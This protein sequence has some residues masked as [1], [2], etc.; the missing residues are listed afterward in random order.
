MTKFYDTNALLNLQGNVLDEY[1]NIS[2]VSLQEL[3]EIKTSRHKDEDVKTR[4]R[5]ILKILSNNQDKYDVVVY[6]D[7]T[8]QLLREHGLEE[9]S[10]NKICACCA[11]LQ[12]DDIEFITDDLAC[13][14]IAKNVFG[15]NVNNTDAGYEKIY[16]GYKLLKG[17]TVEINEALSDSDYLSKFN[18]NEYLLIYNTDVDN[19][20]EMR[21]DGEKFVNL[22]LPNS[23][24]IKGKNALQRCALDM[25]NNPNITICAV[26]GGVGSGKSYTCTRMALYAVKEKGNQ[27][28]ILGVRSPIGEGKEIGFLPGDFESKTD[29]FFLPIEQQLEGGAFELASLKQQGIIDANIPLFMK[30]TTYNSTIMIVDEAEDMTGK[31]LRLIGT[32]LGEDS[33]I[34]LSGDY[35][36]AVTQANEHNALIQ[37]VNKFKG[38]PKFGCVYLDEDVRSETSKM[39]AGLLD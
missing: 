22:K 19:E 9:T 32:R 27:S 5:K 15:L 33:R 31:E 8:K 28:T 12:R 17:N 34:F 11:S 1:F 21:F 26:I 14:L 3:E 35:K 7:Y 38:S 4:C 6:G 36:Q 16:K 29:A 10:D 24:Y 2:V 20:S 25:L 37:M 18:T 30:G 39:F 23:R 13:M